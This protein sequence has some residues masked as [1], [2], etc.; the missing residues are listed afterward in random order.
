MRHRASPT[1]VKNS[2]PVFPPLQ[3]HATWGFPRCTSHLSPVDSAGPGRPAP[4]RADAVPIKRSQRRPGPAAP[5]H[6]SSPLQALI[7]S[8]RS[9]RGREGSIIP[10]L[11]LPFLAA[12]VSLRERLWF[13]PWRGPKNSQIS[14]PGKPAAQKIVHPDSMFFRLTEAF[15][16]EVTTPIF[17][18]CGERHNM[19]D[20]SECSGT[21]APPP[22]GPASEDWQVSLSPF[23]LF[24]WMTG[25]ALL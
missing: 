10:G 15:I 13:V 9:S 25:G 2:S 5:V 12:S 22:A 3:P 18:V 6:P 16:N 23:Q 4:L 8:G 11:L 20:R 24:I 1:S 14:K 21:P 17:T 7:S 19:G